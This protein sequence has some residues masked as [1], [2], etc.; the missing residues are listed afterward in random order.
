MKGEGDYFS[1][2][3]DY[4]CHPF[5]YITSFFYMAENLYCAYMIHIFLPLYLLMDTKA[6]SLICLYE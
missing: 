2:C 1:S 3:E 6:D 5:S 4:Y